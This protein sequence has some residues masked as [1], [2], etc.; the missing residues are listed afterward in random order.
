[1]TLRKVAIIGSGN[2][3]STIAKIIG[4]NV[5]KYDEFDKEVRMWVFEELIGGQKLTSII[6]EKHENVKYLPGIALPT[7]VVAIPDVVETAQNADIYIFVLPHQFLGKVCQQLKPVIKKTA[8]GVSLIKGLATSG[9]SG[10]RLLTDMIREELSIPCAVMMGANLASEVSR[11]NYCE[12]T[13]GASDPVIGMEIKKLFQTDYFRMVVI[14][15]EVGA[16]LCGALKNIVAVG[17]GLIEGLGYG[18]NTKAAVI[19][20][21]FMEMKSFIYQFFGD[22]NPQEGTFLESCGVADLITTCYG[23]RNKQMGIA[24]TKGNENLAELENKLLNGQSAQGPLTASEVYSMLKGR[25]L[26]EKFPL[27]A[28]VHRICSRQLPPTE[29][30]NCL[31]NHPE[32]M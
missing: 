24:L 30:I 26:L 3:G 25:N 23:G 18:D 15:D 9:D 27:F 7:N 22:R 12:G 31:S 11:E 6:N 32:H 17:A 2:W 4:N 20:L 14:K 28:A 19:R 10:I 13:I 16:E 5:Q 8:Y 21:G 29:L 1:M